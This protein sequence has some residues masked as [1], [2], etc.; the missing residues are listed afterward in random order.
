LSNEAI[1]KRLHLSSKSVENQVNLLYDELDISRH[2][3]EYQPRV[4]A[5]LL[6]LES[7][8]QAGS[9]DNNKP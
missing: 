1:A 3:R 7:A 6:Y 2:D 4:R 9:N 8:R 5:A